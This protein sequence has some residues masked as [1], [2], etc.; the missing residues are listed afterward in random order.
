MLVD[1]FRRN[2]DS[3]LMKITDAIAVSNNRPAGERRIQRGVYEIGHFN[4]D[5]V[6]GE[7]MIKTSQP[8]FTAEDIDMVRL[9]IDMDHKNGRTRDRQFPW[10]NHPDD[11]KLDPAL[12]ERLHKGRMHPDR[13]QRDYDDPEYPDRTPIRMTPYGVCDTPEQLLATYDFEADPRNLVI[14]LTQIV[15]ADQSERGGWRWHKWGQYIGD[16]TPRHEYLYYEVDPPIDSVYCFHVYEL[17][18]FMD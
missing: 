18:P 14:S 16:H 4:F 13:H 8:S 15:R 5:H 1:P 6:I 2:P 12:L 7:E 10:M 11:L 3:D 17:K 9:L